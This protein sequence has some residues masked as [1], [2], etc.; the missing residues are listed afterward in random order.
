M[1][2]IKIMKHLYE[3]GMVWGGGTIGGGRGKERIKACYMYIL[4]DSIKKPTKHCKS[5]EE[6]GGNGNTMEGV[7]LFKVHHIHV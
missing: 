4:K 1:M 3:R 5:R 6:E 2:I 7:G